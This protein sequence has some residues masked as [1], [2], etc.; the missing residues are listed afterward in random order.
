MSEDDDI[1][2][3]DA[4]E[5]FNQKNTSEKTD[6]FENPGRLDE[7]DIP[8]LRTLLGAIREELV[9]SSQ[10]DVVEMLQEGG[11]TA[12]HAAAFV[13]ETLNRAPPKPFIVRELRE[14]DPEECQ[15]IINFAVD[16]YITQQDIESLFDS[17]SGPDDSIERSVDMF[18]E[19]LMILLRGE[20]PLS[21]ID[22]ELQSLDVREEVRNYAID[23]FERNRSDISEMLTFRNVQDIRFDQLER[24]E[25]R[26]QETNRILQELLEEIRGQTSE[27]DWD[28]YFD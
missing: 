26:Q 13:E 10:Q 15:M 1:D 2:I 6:V 24:I 21:V 16:S 25:R 28:H 4:I 17:V 20:K 18:C 8:Y 9:E 5:W 22:E 14:F 23:K 19:Y 3:E 11:L 12:A 7:S 27:E